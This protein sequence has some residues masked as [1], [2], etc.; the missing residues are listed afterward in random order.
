MSEYTQGQLNK[1][2]IEGL[3]KRVDMLFQ[4]NQTQVETSNTILL[5]L[6]RI[7]T[8]NKYTSNELLE[9]KKE[10]GE[11]TKDSQ[12][13][14]DTVKTTKTRVDIC[15]KIVWFLFVSI[16]GM[17]FYIIRDALAKGG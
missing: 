3:D 10:H 11:H 7:E 16:M 9:I 2:A 15:V 17:A 8:N 14:R 6:E 12:P 5:T 4:L 13:V 1:Q